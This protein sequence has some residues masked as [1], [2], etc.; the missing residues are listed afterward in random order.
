MQVVDGK[1]YGWNRIMGAFSVDA[2]IGIVACLLLGLLL[3][4]FREWRLTT[5]VPTTDI[6]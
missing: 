5:L 4:Y 2:G 1:A 6:V 3:F